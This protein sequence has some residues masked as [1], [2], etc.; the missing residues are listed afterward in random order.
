MFLF[1]FKQKTAYEMRIS[2]WISDACS[3]D[4]P[5]RR[6][7][8]RVSRMQRGANLLGDGLRPVDQL[9]VR[10]RRVVA[11]AEAALEDPQVAARA[12]LVARAEL[13]EQ[14]ADRLDRQSNRLNY[15]H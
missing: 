3:S 14:L 8:F 12:A 1:F 6:P 10:H 2:D 13:D 5:A 11:I 4:L 15:S 9:H 7:G